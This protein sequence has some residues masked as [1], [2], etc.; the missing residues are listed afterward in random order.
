M[1]FPIESAHDLDDPILSSLLAFLGLFLNELL[2]NPEALEEG[3][4]RQFVGLP[5]SRKQSTPVFRQ[6]S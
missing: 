5:I 2:R 1:T 6:G 4:I 3:E